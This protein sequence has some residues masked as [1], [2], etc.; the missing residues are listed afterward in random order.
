MRIKITQQQCQWLQDNQD[1]FIIYNGDIIYFDEFK[2][3]IVDEKNWL[4]KHKTNYYITNIKFTKYFIEYEALFT[5]TDEF[6]KKFMW[7]TINEMSKCRQKFIKFRKQLEGLG[8]RIINKTEL[9]NQ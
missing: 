1:R 7:Q 9:E 2:F 6:I 5:M 8:Y 4:G 3:E